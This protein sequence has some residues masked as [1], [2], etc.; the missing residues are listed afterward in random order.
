MQGGLGLP[1]ESYYRE[2][3]FAEIRAGVRR[4]RR[5]PCSRLGRHRRRRPTRRA[6]SWRS[7]PGSPP[8]TGTA[9]AT[10]DVVEDLQ[11][12]RPSPSLRALAPA[13]DW[14]AWLDGARRH[15]ATVLAEVIV[16]QPTYLAAPRP[17]RSTR[18]RSRTGRLW[19]TCHVVRAPRAVP[20]R[21]LRRGELRLLRPHPHRHARAA[22]PLEAR[23]RRWSRARSARRSASEYVARHFPPAAKAQMD[24]LVANLVEAY[25]RSIEP[26]RLDER[27]DQGAGLR[28][29]RHVPPKIGYPDKCRDYSRAAR[30]TAT[31]CS[32]TSRARAAFE[33]DR[34]LGQDRRARSTATSGS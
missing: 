11:P 14:A 8:A 5:P 26:A 6:G 29:A 34:Q 31:T 10:R 32:A 25:R 30:S 24:E 22:G 17:R 13:F 3:K 27:G 18:S 19:L 1:D 33:T 16:R 28:E 2:E 20:H 9:S 23:R 4:P 15:R 12:A 7:R 21:R